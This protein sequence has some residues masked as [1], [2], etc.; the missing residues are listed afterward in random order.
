[1]VS[2]TIIRDT[3]IIPL[4]NALREIRTKVSR[5]D[6]QATYKDLRRPPEGLLPRAGLRLA[7]SRRQSLRLARGRQSLCLA[8]GRLSSVRLARASLRQIRQGRPK[9]GRGQAH[10]MRVPTRVVAAEHSGG[11]DN[12]HV[13]HSGMITPTQIVRARRLTPSDGMLNTTS[14]ANEPSG[15]I[16][17]PYLT[18]GLV[19]RRNFSASPDINLNPQVDYPPRSSSA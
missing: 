12:N 3:R 8:R 1:V 16:S 5:G 2:R 19:F 17:P 7:R 15:A 13:Q 4:T 10:L 6:N 18:P 14:Q 11:Q 9:T